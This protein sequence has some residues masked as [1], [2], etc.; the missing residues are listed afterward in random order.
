MTANLKLA[1]TISVGLHAAGFIGWPTTVP[2]QFDVERAPTSVELFL[3]APPKT[4][5]PPVAEVTKPEPEP[6]PEPELLPPLQEEPEPIQQTV[7]AEEHKGAITEI[8]PGYLRN[9]PPV[10]PR[11]A[12]E[13]GWEG[14]VLLE[15]EV[16]TSGRCG[17]INVLSSSGHDVLDRTAVEAI[18]RWVFKPAKRWNQP[19]AFWVEIPVTFRLTDHAVYLQGN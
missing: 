16:L 13:H 1:L 19:V 9:P 4:T 3:I 8:L 11:L 10:Y 5:A 6:T 2:V 17:T 15:V 18:R 12:R 7:V 14:T